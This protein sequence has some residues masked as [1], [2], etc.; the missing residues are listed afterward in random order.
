MQFTIILSWRPVNSESSRFH[1]SAADFFGKGGRQKSAVR[2]SL[3][4]FFRPK[5]QF[6]DPGMENIFQP[7]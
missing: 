3:P 5:G 6:A 4:D 1:L 2:K 7:C